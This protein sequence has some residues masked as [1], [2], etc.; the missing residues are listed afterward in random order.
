[1][2]KVAELLQSE[3]DDPCELSLGRLV[4]LGL[5]NSWEEIEAVSVRAEKEFHLLQN[6][7]KMKA[8]WSEMDLS[9]M[10]YK[11]TRSYVVKV[12]DDVLSLLDD[13]LVKIQTMLGSPFIRHIIESAK[14]CRNQLLLFNSSLSRH[15][16][17]DFNI[18]SLCSRRY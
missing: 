15:G 7:D 5:L 18:Y 3:F 6:I 8:E 4:K 16:K 13:H 9:L 17:R 14:V 1:M 11:D 12:S 10:E 2:V